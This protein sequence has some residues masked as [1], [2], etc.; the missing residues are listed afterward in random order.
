MS[1]LMPWRPSASATRAVVPV[2]P[3]GSRTTPGV[4]GAVGSG[5]SHAYPSSTFSA[6]GSDQ[7]VAVRIGLLLSSGRPPYF[8]PSPPRS[9]D[10]DEATMRP[11]SRT[12]GRLPS[13]HSTHTPR[14]DQPVMMR[15]GHS[16]GN[17]AK[18]STPNSSGTRSGSVAIV[19]TEPGSLP[20]GLSGNPANGPVMDWCSPFAPMLEALPG[21]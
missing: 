16:V 18:W 15:R 2:P 3:N 8:S 5:Q 6:L 13:P 17:A 10:P 11:V 20:R 19:Q 9:G 1:T 12:T 14:G 7:P 21:G 4:V